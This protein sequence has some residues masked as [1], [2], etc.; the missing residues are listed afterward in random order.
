M[1]WPHRFCS[2][3]GAPFQNTQ[4]WAA[5]NI[6]CPSCGSLNTIQPG[7]ASGMFYAGLGAHAMSH[8][9]AWN[10]WMAEFQAKKFYDSRRH[11]TAGDHHAGQV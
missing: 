7:T 9:Q 8:E 2:Q 3:C 10:E 11:Q 5:A 4:W 6:N 1:M